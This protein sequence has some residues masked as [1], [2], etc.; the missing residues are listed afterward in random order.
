MGGRGTGLDVSRYLGRSEAE[1]TGEYSCI[2]Q[3]GNIKFLVQNE[4]KRVSVP[5]FSNTENRIYVTLNREGEISGIT[6]YDK[7]HRDVFSIHEKHSNEANGD[8][9]H[10]HTSLRN[11]RIKTEG[12]NMS[13]EHIELYKYI[14][15]IYNKYDLKNIAKKWRK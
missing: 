9:Y 12:R 7:N 15:S 3:E 2:H 14:K 1:R 10:E 13:R 4:G 5:V 11:G 8:L 6:Q